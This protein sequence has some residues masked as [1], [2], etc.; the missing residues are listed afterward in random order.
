MA[1]IVGCL[2]M[3]HSP[4]LLMPALQWGD[5]PDRVRPPFNPP[6]G[7]ENE[8]SDDVFLAKEKRCQDAI[9]ALKAKLDDWAPD[10]VVI[11]GD[12]QEENI[13]AD[14]TPPFTIFIGDEADAGRK[15]HYLGENP[16]DQTER[17]P[18]QSDLALELVETLMDEGFDPAWSRHT[19]YEAGLGHAFGRPLHYLMPKPNPNRR[20]VPVML[21]T[22]YDPAPTAARCYD[23]GAALGSALRQS[24]KAGRIVVIAS[25]GLSH[26]KINEALDQAFID[27]LERFDPDYFKA[28]PASDLV[29]GTSEL[30]NWIAV[31]AIAG[32]GAKMI[33][34]VPCYRN[35]NGVGCAM[36]FAYWEPK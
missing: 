35:A 15:F 19:R 32:Q 25:G 22:F 11:V 4:Q 34:Y 8:L 33:D 3:S 5:L 21:N 31:A 9:A 20:V 24:D 2:G 7:I 13:Q 10:V 16:V 1:E 36:G 27:A 17:Y 14:N 23:F 30:R 28:M 26:T 29:H 18:M 12:D 6:P